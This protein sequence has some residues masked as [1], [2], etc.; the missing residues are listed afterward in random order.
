MG[1]STIRIAGLNERLRELGHK[2][3]DDGDVAV[4]NVE[5]LRVGGP[6]ARYLKHT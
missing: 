5:E 1:L 6:K 3:R 2:V 4:R